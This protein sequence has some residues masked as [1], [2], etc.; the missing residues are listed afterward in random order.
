[1]VDDFKRWLKGDEEVNQPQQVDVW[2]SPC[3]M[4]PPKGTIKVNFDA[5]INKN[6]DFVGLGVIARDC[7]GNLLEAKQLS[8]S[9]ITDAHTAALMAASYAVSFSLEVGFFNVIFGG[10]ALNAIREVN[11]NHPYLFR[12]GHFIE[13]IKQDVVYLRSNSFVHVS[14]ALNEAAHTLARS[15]AA[16]FCYDVWLEDIPSCIFDIVSREQRITRS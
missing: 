7:M 13:G 4:K 1:V 14:R 15:A 10:D 8:K 6:T 11:S 3:W 9:L 12:S 5:A 16:N 2:V